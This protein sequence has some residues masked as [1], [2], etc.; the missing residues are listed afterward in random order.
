MVPVSLWQWQ[1]CPAS[2][3]DSGGGCGPAQN[4]RHHQLLPLQQA[5]QEEPAVCG[6]QDQLTLGGGVEGEPEHAAILAQPDVVRL[7]AG[8]VRY[9]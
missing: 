3:D 1:R 6:E 7:L 8:F 4:R 2:P 5:Q 9:L